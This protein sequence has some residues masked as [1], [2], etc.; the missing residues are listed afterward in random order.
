MSIYQKM[1]AAG[2]EIEHHQSD[3]WVPKNEVSTKI[4]VEKGF[5]TDELKSMHFRCSIT[6]DI[7]YDIPFA[8]DPFWS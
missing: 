1:V 3:L 6:G 8:Y 4:L 5:T 2:V 7:W